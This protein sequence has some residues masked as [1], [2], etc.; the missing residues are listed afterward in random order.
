MYNS[1]RINQLTDYILE[2]SGQYDKNTLC[3]MVVEEFNLTKDR[4]IYYGED[5]AIRFSSSK[6]RAFSNTV[7]S[8]SNLK[9]YDHLP[10]IVCL[11]TPFTNELFLAN[12]T[13]LNKISHSSHDL[14]VDNI[15]GS[16]NGS[17]I[18]QEFQG[19]SNHPSNF[20][21]LFAIHEGFTFEDNLVRLVE[22]T[23]N[24]RPTGTKFD[25]SPAQVRIIQDSVHRAVEFMA[26]ESYL[27]LARELDR[28]VEEVKES[29]IRASAN[30][31]VNVRGRMI[32]YLITQEVEVRQD[33]ETA[34][35]NQGRL[36]EIFTADD[37]GDYG[38]IFDDFIT[39][40]D[41]KSKLL[42]GSS[43]PKGYNIDKLLEF[44][45]QDKSVYLVYL[46]GIDEQQVVTTRL[47]SLYDSQLMQGTRIFKH[48][49]GR[50]SRGVIQYSGDSINQ[51]IE[52]P[53]PQI[54]TAESI[55]YINSLL[56]L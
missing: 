29:I 32:E 56:E 50:N 3:E 35:T 18:A 13:F 49:A 41:I 37:L 21:E 31:N 48:W 27:T 42:F 9:K 17:D 46:I 6:S 45:S 25:P 43:N 2:R 33:L 53:N 12:T 52:H 16:F 40:T 34:L 38:M 10:F 28:R 15:R 5:Y 44:I 4:S 14:R 1:Q 26:S 8:L 36:P 20:E 11:V 24:I 47:C 39:Q 22:A 19:I 51:I 7:L 55:A 30:E 54:K 23:N